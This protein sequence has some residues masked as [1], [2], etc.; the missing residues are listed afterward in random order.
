M[1]ECAQT[2]YKDQGVPI[3]IVA[4]HGPG[5]VEKA[6]KDA[7]LMCLGVTHLYSQFV[8]QHPGLVEQNM[9]ESVYVRPAGI[10][11]R[12]GNPRGIKR[13]ED[14][15]GPGVLLLNVTC[16]GQVAVWEDLAGRRGLILAIFQIYDG[17]IH[18]SP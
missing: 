15:A 11:V 10:L 6:K 4:G 9:W 8:L 5:W 18:Q 14:L 3:T 16:P 1:E 2:F 13:L 7:D 12:K 17:G